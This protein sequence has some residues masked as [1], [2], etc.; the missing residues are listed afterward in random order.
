[1]RV[2]DNCCMEKGP[3]RAHSEY[4]ALPPGSGAVA[5]AVTRQAT[6]R[7]ASSTRP[8]TATSEERCTTATEA[9][10]WRCCRLRMIELL[11]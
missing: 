11:A 5:S 9:Q 7:G 8:G 3:S 2:N 4:G 1:M 6:G 10:R